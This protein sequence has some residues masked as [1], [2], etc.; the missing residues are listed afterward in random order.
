VED[1]GERTFLSDHGAEY[2][3]RPEWFSL[4]SGADYSGV[5]LCGL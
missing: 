4:L 3:F 2:R 1:G 5:Y